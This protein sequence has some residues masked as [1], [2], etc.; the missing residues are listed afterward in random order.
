MFWRFAPLVGDHAPGRRRANR[1]AGAPPRFIRRREFRFASLRSHALS[2]YDRSHDSR[3]NAKHC[4]ADRMAPRLNR[5]CRNCELVSR[6][7]RFHLH[8]LAFHLRNLRDSQLQDAIAQ[9]RSRF[10]R[11]DFRR[12]FDDAKQFLGALFLVDGL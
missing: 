11:V 8:W 9:C 10:R 1:F 6:G 12:K 2:N 5:D 7:S 4:S 3:H